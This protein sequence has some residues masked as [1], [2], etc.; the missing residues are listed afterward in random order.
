MMFINDLKQV[1][2]EHY[3]YYKTSHQVT[4]SKKKLGS[5]HTL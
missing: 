3:T 5:K 4:K 1:A 2:I